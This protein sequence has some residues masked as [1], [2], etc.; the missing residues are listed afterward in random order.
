MKIPKTTIASRA[1]AKKKAPPKP[2]VRKR[3]KRVKETKKEIA[4]KAAAKR[5][6]KR[7]KKKS[8]IVKKPMGRPTIILDV[9]TVRT[10]AAQGMTEQQIADALKV[11]IKTLISNKKNREEFMEA[12]TEGKAKGI[13]SMT[14]ALF[15]IGLAG[16]F[17]AINK[18]LNNR[19]PDNWKDRVDHHVVGTIA[20]Y[21]DATDLEMAGLEVD[22][23]D[24]LEAEE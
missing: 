6:K 19:D 4:K 12:L 18:Y 2:P 8:L 13:D 7:A 24:L 1:K 14:N 16:N 23:T 3:K 17:Q 10:L 20:V 9:E 15:R 22:A 21:P 5:K 11:N